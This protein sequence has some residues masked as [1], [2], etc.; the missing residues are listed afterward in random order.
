MRSIQS[1]TFLKD[2]VIEYFSQIPDFTSKEKI[3]KILIGFS[4]GPDS[5]CL[6]LLLNELKDRL[7]IEIV[8]AYF[9]HM[10]RSQEELST[11]LSFIRSIADKYNLTLEIGTD[12]GLIGELSPQIGEE[13]AA[14]KARY[15]FLEETMRKYSC[16]YLAL[17]HNLD[18]TVE[19]IVMRFF[20]GSGKNGTHPLL[21]LQESTHFVT[22]TQIGRTAHFFSCL[23]NEDL[24][25]VHFK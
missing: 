4:G 11:E 24:K 18:D 5:M 1:R 9:N 10:L 23:V 2:Q 22:I 13:G 19:T 21:L 17:A 3:K 8:L 14:R 6:M 16:D 15:I 12:S 20:K 7:G 25:P